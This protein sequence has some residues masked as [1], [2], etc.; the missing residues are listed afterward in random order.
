MTGP[1][2][3]SQEIFMRWSTSVRIAGW[4][5]DLSRVPSGSLSVAPCWTASRIQVSTRT[6]AR[7]SINGPTT[8]ASS[9]GSPAGRGFHERD[10]PVEKGVIHVVVEV[11]AL[12]GNAGLSGIRESARDASLGGQAQVGVGFDDDRGHCLPVR[13]GPV[14]FP[15]LSFKLQPTAALPVKLKA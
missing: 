11:N 8:V 12:D 3:S 9:A 2:T 13:A 6:A 10:Q 5:K 14:F 1:K 7:S 4:I 15:A